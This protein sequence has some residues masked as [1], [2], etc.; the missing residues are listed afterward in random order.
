MPLFMALS[1]MVIGLKPQIRTIKVL[2]LIK[3]RAIQLLIPFFGWA[4][5]YSLVNL[6]IYLPFDIIKYPDQGLWFLYALFI[7]NIAFICTNILNKYLNNYVISCLILTIGLH[8]IS[9]IL[10]GLFGSF[11]VLKFY[12]YYMV[13]YFISKKKLIYCKPKQKYIATILSFILFIILGYYWKRIE[14]SFYFFDVF[15]Y[16]QYINLAYKVITAITGIICCILIFTSIKSS[17]RIMQYIGKRSLA[18]YA[19]HYIIIDLLLTIENHNIY[20]II[21]ILPF[22]LAASL[23][24]EKIISS[25]NITSLI[26]LGKKQI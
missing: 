8:Y 9:I 3:K 12:F 15:T 5:V 11:L 13:G 7:T 26:L 6:N 17:C 22:T 23:L 2:D 4:L 10:N 18:I 1:G 19:I 24:L 16:N 14:L 25:N 21:V 20:F